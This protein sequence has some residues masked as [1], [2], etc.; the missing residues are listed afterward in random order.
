MGERQW[1]GSK[2]LS[3]GDKVASVFYSGNNVFNSNNCTSSF[4]VAKATTTLTITVNDIMVG[5]DEKISVTVLSGVSGNIT[6]TCGDFNVTKNIPLS[7]K[8]YR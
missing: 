5:D 4:N 7:C 8:A 3:A 6:I 1:K 2:S